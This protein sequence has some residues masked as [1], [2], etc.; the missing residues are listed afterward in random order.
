MKRI[1]LNSLGLGLI[2][3]LASCGGDDPLPAP[4]PSFEAS[5]ELEVFEI[6]NPIQFTNNSTNAST[7][8][9]DF[10]DGNTSE[11][12]NP[13]HAYED[14][15]TY[16]V[17]LTAF[18]EDEQSEVAEQTIEVGER[19]LLEIV[20]LSVNFDKIDADGNIGPW[21]V[22]SGPDMTIIFGP[23]GDDGSNTIGAGPLADLDQATFQGVTLSLNESVPLTNE[24]WVLTII[25]DDTDIE[26]NAFEVMIQSNPFNPITNSNSF[27]NTDTLQGSVQIAGAGFDIIFVFEID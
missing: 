7:Y 18:T 3:L 20:V 15:G 27:I 23:E 11:D 8:M 5:T 2:G 17:T 9:W 24:N 13:E 14:P 10:G 19:K 22:G 12:I 21:D 26:A 6:I 25:D 4:V 16:T 1:L